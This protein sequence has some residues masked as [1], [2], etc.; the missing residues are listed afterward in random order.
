MKPRLRPESSQLKLFQLHFDQL[1]N[2][3]HPL[4]LLAKKIDWN[5]FQV[6]LEDCYSPDLGASAKSVR[7]IVGLLYL[8]HAFN[9][10]DEMLL[11]R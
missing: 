11:E 3:D 1:L 5:R 2:P 10:P 7:L 6:A 8:K 9:L 4:V